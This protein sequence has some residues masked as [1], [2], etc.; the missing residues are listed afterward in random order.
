L[1][2]IDLAGGGCEDQGGAVFG[3]E[4][5]GFICRFCQLIAWVQVAFE[6]LDAMSGYG[7]W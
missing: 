3:E 2:H 7:R 1:P 6:I 5:D 4:G